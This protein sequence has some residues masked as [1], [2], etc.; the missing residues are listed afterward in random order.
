MESTGI[1]VAERLGIYLESNE[2]L[3]E[4]A[5]NIRIGVAYFRTLLDLYEGNRYLAVI[6]YNAGRGNVARWIEEGIIKP[7]GEDIENVPFPETNMYVRRI[8]RNYEIYRRLY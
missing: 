6:A 5:I 1:E 4:P 2:S 7:T 3:Y 8:F